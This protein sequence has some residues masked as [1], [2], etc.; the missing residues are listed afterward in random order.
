VLARACHLGDT[1]VNVRTRGEE[2]VILPWRHNMSSS[3][4]RS[5]SGR[6]VTYDKS[7]GVSLK[8][9]EFLRSDEGKRQLSNAKELRIL[10]NTPGITAERGK[11]Q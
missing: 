3:A 8:V 2:T 6:F 11:K 1:C 4:K 5:Q 7:G 9:S 10:T